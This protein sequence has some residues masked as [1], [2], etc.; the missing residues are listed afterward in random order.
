MTRFQ[1]TIGAPLT[2]AIAIVVDDKRA[3]A[4][5]A[6]RRD[7]RNSAA[8][9]RPTPLPLR[10]TDSRDDAHEWQVINAAGE[11]QR[12]SNATKRGGE[13]PRLHTLRTSSMPPT[14]RNAK[15]LA[16]TG[17]DGGDSRQT[18]TFLQSTEFNG[19]S[20]AE[21]ALWPQEIVEAAPL[22]IRAHEAQ[23]RRHAPHSRLYA[24]SRV[25]Q[26]LSLP[27][28]HATARMDYNQHR[29]EDEIYEEH[30]HYGGYDVRRRHRH[31]HDDSAAAT[32]HDQHE[33]TPRVA[34]GVATAA[35]NGDDERRA[36]APLELLAKAE[37]M[38]AAL[39]TG[40]DDEAA[41]KADD[42]DVY[43]HDWWVE[44]MQ[45]SVSND[46]EMIITYARMRK[47]MP[48]STFSPPH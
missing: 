6:E 25:Q 48:S 27:P 15:P 11:A 13:S 38:R 45:P 29:D 21:G 31:H 7:E 9:I 19:S 47:F 39:M 3:D 35:S 12:R 42:A 34:H 44:R 5:R 4:D 30:Y 46:G 20:A 36:S 2:T 22:N 43:E 18:S 28:S 41:A 8:S 24:A 16:K 40:G 14:R 1:P 32:S 26:P 37:K 17:D 10:V 33:P 23:R